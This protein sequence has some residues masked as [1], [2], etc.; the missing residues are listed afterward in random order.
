MVVVVLML[1]IVSG[2]DM[3]MLMWLVLVMV[4]TEVI[5]ALLINVGGGSEW[6]V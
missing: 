2:G 5:K 1:R 6:S 3:H 4:T